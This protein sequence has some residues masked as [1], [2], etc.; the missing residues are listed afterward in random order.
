MNSDTWITLAVLL[1]TLALLIRGKPGPSMVVSG[2][3]ILLL[4]LAV[5]TPAEALSGFSNPAPFTVAALYVV[6]RAVEKTGGLQPLIRVLLA[7]S[8]SSGGKPG[9]G[10]MAKLLVPVAGASA[11]LNNTPIVAMVSPQ[12]ETW[13]ERRGQSPSH[14]LM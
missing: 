1:G 4:G 8:G 5:V 10:S 3:V 14:Y 6:A 11:F 2:A 13:A 12:V 7:G 9:W